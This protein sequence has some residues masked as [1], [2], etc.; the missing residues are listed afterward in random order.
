MVK[1][2][3]IGVLMPNILVPDESVD[4]SRWAVVACDQFTSEPEYWQETES[5]VGDAPSTLRIMLPEL[6][7]D[8]PDEDDRIRAVRETMDSYMNNGVLR[9]LGPGLV[10]LKRTAMGKTR[11]GMVLALDL[12]LYDYNRGSQTLIRAT[13]GTIVERIPPRL[14]IRKGAP[15]E[16][17][18]IIILIDDPEKT[19][20][21]PLFAD[22]EKELMSGARKH[23][24]DFE[25]MQEG[26]HI[27]S[28]FI[29]DE[30]K[31]NAVI[32]SLTA[33]KKEEPGKAPLLFALGDG[34][35]SFATAKANWESIKA[36]LTEEE[37]KT[38]PARFALVEIENLHDEGIVF[39]PIHRVLFDV[40]PRE[41]IVALKDEMNKRSETCEPEFC[42]D[43]EDWKSRM[44]EYKRYKNLHVIPFEA[45]GFY[46]FF[47]VLNPEAQIEAGTL[48]TA[49]DSVME[50]MGIKKQNLDYVH[51][52][53]V[54]ERL[55]QKKGN[56][57][58]YLPPMG[59]DKLFTTVMREGALPRKTF[60][61]GE[62]QEKRYYLECR[63]IF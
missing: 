4:Y 42:F 7:L 50:N 3:N 15:L 24:Y 13:E 63:K 6:Y 52:D 8:S 46:G 30:D 39:E 58:I 32:D 29:N 55:S 19:V 43:K 14:R 60:S 41:V 23:L 35:H 45:E 33:L 27:S 56:L 57:G 51:G 28:F 62:A 1:E 9:D 26:G 20:I 47:K 49:L 10:L 12:E 53:A 17:P 18:H 44:D 38:H 22:C 16:L 61:M 25:L 40:S 59:K 54:V 5:I 48:Q 21:E 31:L 37:Q 2:N 11:L 36:T 34:N